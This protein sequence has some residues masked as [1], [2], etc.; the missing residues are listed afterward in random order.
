MT[1]DSIKARY[2]AGRMTKAQLAVYTR[3][4][5][6]TPAQYKE[7]TREDY[8]APAGENEILNILLGEEA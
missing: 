7:I 2:D 8:H 5:V 1:F 3:K 4:G 6:V